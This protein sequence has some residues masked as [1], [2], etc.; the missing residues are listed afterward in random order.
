MVQPEPPRAP[1]APRALPGAIAPVEHPHEALGPTDLGVRVAP[2][3]L[4]L[5]RVALGQSAR[6]TFAGQRRGWVLQLAQNATL[7]TPAY[8]RGK[9]YVG[10]GF[11]S[12]T[13][14]ALD[15]HTGGLSWVGQT[16]DGGP[17][18]AIIE[19]DKVLFNTESCTLFAF[20]LASGRQRW[21]H[22][23]GDPLMS[24][25]A[26]AHGR[27]FSAYP[28]GRSPSGFSFSGM[29]MRTGAYLWTR[30][31]PAD[32]LTAP[33]IDG[34]DVYVTTMDG[35]VARFRARDGAVRW[36]RSLGATS[37]P[38]VD[39]G[40]LYVARR[41]P[42]GHERQVVLDTRDGSVVS[43]GPA[44]RAPY[45]ARRAD[46]G[47]TQ[48]GWAY[49]GARP[50]YAEGRLYHAMG[51]EVVARDAADGR[52]VWRRRYPG[53]I[54]Q[55]G[56][57]SPA[58]V[59]SQLVVGT[60]GGDVY[61]MDIDTGMTTWAYHIGEPIAFQPAVANGWVYLATAR[62]K[63]LG[64]EVGDP[65][66]DG[67]HMWGGNAEHN[68]LSA[69]EPAAPEEPTPLQ[70]TLRLRAATARRG[71]APAPTEGFPLLH[72]SVSA[73]VS[74][75]V[76]R[77]TVEQRFT[78][79][80]DHP[81]DAEY[82]FPLPAN[83]AVD[84]MDL[85]VGARAIHGTIQRRAEARQT[86]QRARAR[87]R[88][89]ALLEQERPNLFRQAVANIRPGEPLRVVLR[90]AQTV[91]WRDG[92]YEFVMPLATGSR[93][94]PG[95][96]GST[97]ERPPGDVDLSARVD[98]GT[99]L[100][101]VT[102]PSH[103]ITITHTGDTVGVT[104]TQG[105]ALPDRDFLLRYRPR[106]ETVTPS[107]LAR[108]DG[109]DGFFTLL[110]H[111]D[112]GA[113]DSAVTPR[114]LVF[115]V[116]TSSSMRGAPMTQA[117]ALVSEA[118]RRLRPEDTF[119]VVRFSDAT[120]EL[121]PAP[122]APT[123][124]NLARARAWVESL[125]AAGATEMLPGLHAALG[126]APPADARMR[127]VVLITDGYIGNEREVLAALT[128]DLGASRVFSFGV[129]GAVNRYLLEQV[130]E[131]GRGVSEVVTPSEDPSAAAERFHTRIARPF[132]TDL[133]VD[134]GGLDVRE[135]YPRA[136]P[137]VFADQPVLVHGRYAQGGEGTI[138]LSGRVRGRAW[139]QRVRVSLPR[140]PGGHEAV[141][142][143]WARARIH[144]LSTAMLLGETP[145]LREEVTRLALRFGLVSDYTSFVAVDEEGS[146]GGRAM[147]PGASANIGSGGGYGYGYGSSG[148]LGM[149]GAG[150]GGSGYGYGTIGLGSVGT[151]GR[152][153]AAITRSY[154]M[155]LEARV[156]AAP[157]VAAAT[158]VVT[159]TIN[160]DVIRAVVRRNI[161][162]VRAA[163]ERAL[164]GHPDAR[165]RVVVRF[166]IGEDGR[167][168][169]AEVTENTTGDP[170]VG[171]DIASAVRSWLFPAPPP[172]SGVVVV[173]YPF[174]FEPSEAPSAA[175][176]HTD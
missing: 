152:D 147:V 163:Y 142:S 24:Q 96:G 132:V 50:A 55:R 38:A 26:A 20:D 161:A 10:A 44:V 104:L 159:G 60:R 89:A 102:S 67:W 5:P 156:T 12:T 81:V 145:A 51:D 95:Q 28:D 74:G 112:A 46:T 119:R 116:D 91:P 77:V 78:N 31:V 114:E 64:L 158:P 43:S 61:G 49:E 57:T 93:Y 97:P 63:V 76:A 71:S 54:T 45:A 29:S 170:A 87:G 166:V 118:L 113:P 8:A 1:E 72:T 53:A 128:R 35:S 115:V 33:V 121:A 108:R 149:L 86:Y 94:T 90:F 131:L 19:D 25:A 143:V 98:L 7:T 59:G 13:V 82:L 22:Y 18:A 173:S 103:P 117:R 144:D 62:G 164:R 92:R 109:D 123:A 153:S 129:G 80:Y 127:L 3:S 122:L 16:P 42:H 68:G 130:A 176:T 56:V 32:V 79:P 160:A 124:E 23:L 36:R 125:R 141:P 58:V 65:S 134:W 75:V 70:G 155:A 47:G 30:P 137:D 17:T 151:V 169:G 146:V 107:V 120:S 69:H 139:T 11:T 148:G 150:S 6:F 110:L 171:A 88:T 9:V 27:V 39:A 174:Q 100:E 140:A 138:Q 99:A 165:G 111:P 84:A 154:P 105:R 83:S 34:E 48:A 2:R 167:V 101:E 168:L 136:L 135:V 66:L 162:Q 37:A 126:A 41:A 21:S 157:M 106:V 14:Y 172:G 52:V 133:A 175:P 4:E 40:R 73:E 85:H 15:A